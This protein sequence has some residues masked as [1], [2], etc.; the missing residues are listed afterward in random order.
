MK[1]NLVY[2][3]SHTDKALTFEWIAKKLDKDKINLHFILLN[4][5]NSC[6]EEKLPA[7]NGPV[8]RIKLISKKKITRLFSLSWLYYC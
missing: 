6:L 7:L 4:P 3:I 5:A 2:I 1:I 8:Y